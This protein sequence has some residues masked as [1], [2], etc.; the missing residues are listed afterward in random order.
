MCQAGPSKTVII[1][2]IL[3]DQGRFVNDGIFGDTGFEINAV[4][5]FNKLP[6]TNCRFN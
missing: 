6:K 2:D 1:F 5:G 3:N 4:S